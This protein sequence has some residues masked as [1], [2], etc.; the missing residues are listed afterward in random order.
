M[1]AE[2]KK[3]GRCAQVL[4]RDHVV[5][6]RGQLSKHSWCAG[7][8]PLQNEAQPY[9]DLSA[10]GATSWEKTREQRMQRGSSGAG[11]DGVEREEARKD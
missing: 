11:R 4:H 1:G 10:T 7:A 5:D 8:S 3:G 6:T 9:S 2:R